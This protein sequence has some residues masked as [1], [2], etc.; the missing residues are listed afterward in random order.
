M[1]GKYR[2]CLDLTQIMQGAGK[3]LRGLRDINTAVDSIWM[4]G[5]KDTASLLE[6]WGEKGK[7]SER[8]QDSAKMQL[9][10]AGEGGSPGMKKNPD[11]AHVS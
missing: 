1:L 10:E 4:R 5:G 6:G 11:L 3:A 8:T 9:L 7:D 2:E